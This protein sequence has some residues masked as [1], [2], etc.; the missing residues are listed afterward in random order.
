MI[1]I[2]G[3]SLRT[4]MQP[5]QKERGGNN[6]FEALRG[7]RECQE[8]GRAV[9]PGLLVLVGSSGAPR[10]GNQ[11]RVSGAPESECAEAA[12]MLLQTAKWIQTKGLVVRHR[13]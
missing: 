13:F 12:E 7:P 4:S 6:D 3:A 10:G 1:T 9:G 11:G 2:S 8:G 5:R